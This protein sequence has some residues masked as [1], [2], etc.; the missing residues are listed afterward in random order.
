MLRWTLSQTHGVEAECVEVY[1]PLSNKHVVNKN[2]VDGS[3]MTLHPIQF[4]SNCLKLE[5]LPSTMVPG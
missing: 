4:M 1:E 2:V 5:N 3:S